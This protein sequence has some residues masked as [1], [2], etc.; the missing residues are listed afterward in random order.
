[1]YNADSVNPQLKTEGKVFLDGEELFYATKVSI[2]ATLTNAKSKPLG[3]KTSKSRN[4]GYELAT[5]ITGYK[6]N[7]FGANILKKYI[8]K[9]I[10]PTFTIQALNNDKNSDFFNKYGNDVITVTGAVL[11][12]DITL[13]DLDASATDYV[14]E[15]LKFE[16]HRF[17]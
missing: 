3:S 8:D 1:M 5:E 17:A 2:K 15:T 13:I 9:G 16:G 12:G 4:V 7:P 10:T 14:Q 11:S 6:V